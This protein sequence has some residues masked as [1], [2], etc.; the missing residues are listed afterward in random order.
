MFTINILYQVIY[1]FMILFTEFV[2]FYFCNY[3]VIRVTS[4]LVLTHFL[5]LVLYDV[6][7]TLW[8]V[9]GLMQ[10]GVIAYAGNVCHLK[11]TVII[12]QNDLDH[13]KINILNWS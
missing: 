11:A 12:E 6:S 3:R 4:S 7:G 1:C 10:E 5:F 13:S 8:V 9:W 2:I